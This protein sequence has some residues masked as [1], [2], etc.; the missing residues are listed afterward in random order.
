MYADP[1]SGAA[2]GTAAGAIAEGYELAGSDV[3]LTTE[4]TALDTAE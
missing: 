3:M 4:G 1:Y 2:T